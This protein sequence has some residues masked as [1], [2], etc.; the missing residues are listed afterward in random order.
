MQSKISLGTVQFGLDY[1]IANKN[2]KVSRQK[3]FE[4]FKYAKASGINSLDTAYAYGQS[5]EVIGAY[6]KQHPDQFQVVSKLPSLD[7]YIPGKAEEFLQL[8]L[9]RLNIKR[10]H[11]YLIHNVE[12]FFTYE[13]LWEELVCLKGKS[14]IDRIGFTLYSPMELETLLE[15][16]IEFDLIQIPYSIFDRRFE[17]YFDILK[18]RRVEIHV[19]SVFLQ[20]LVFLKPDDLQG[21]LLKAQKQINDLRKLS[22]D[23]NVSIS[24]ICLNF[25]LLNKCVDKVVIGI[26]NLDH[27]RKNMKSLALFNRINQL[28]QELNNL[29]IHDENILMPFK[30]HL[31]DRKRKK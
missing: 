22:Q 15:K 27:L 12:N 4:I 16:N 20:G 1:G 9:N 11:G 31:E 18:K 21:N 24:A 3:V 7:A 17:K 28:G 29:I 30:W 26:D 10:L 6:L 14:R 25:V 19:R 23:H 13:D 8:T 5:E 2:G